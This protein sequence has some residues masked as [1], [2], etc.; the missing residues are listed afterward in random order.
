MDSVLPLLTQYGYPLLGLIVFLEAIGFPV[1][2]APVLLAV[3]AAAATGR[4]DPV[5]CLSI[6]LAGMMAADIILFILGRW[7]GWWLLGLL[8]RV[9]VNP[10]AC[11][12]AS[13]AHFHKRGRTALLFTKF[14]PGINTMAAPMAGSMN[15]NPFVFLR[16][17]LGGALIYI[18]FYGILGFTFSEAIGAITEWVGTLGRAVA[19]IAG[20]A[21]AI[22]FGFRIWSAWRF[23]RA[24]NIPR[25]SIDELAARLNDDILIADVRSHG[26]YDANAERILGSIRIEPNRL[27]EALADL[28]RDRDVYLYCS[29]R[30]EATSQRVAELLT[31]AGYK[32]KVVVGGLSAWKKAGHPLERVPAE[33]VVHLPRFA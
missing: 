24:G 19:V 21:I 4:L 28:P 2:A 18:L 10:E 33:D 9:S 8:C 32:P 6:A 5:I 30:N 17:D 11:I 20:I 12:Y 7:T 1:P 23:R 27:P 3:G 25:V 29:C 14:L 15:M 16:Y 13:A 26:Y 31:E 22:Y